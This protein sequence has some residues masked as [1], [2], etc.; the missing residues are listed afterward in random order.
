[1]IT[2]IEK[3]LY[4]SNYKPEICRRVIPVF[5]IKDELEYSIFN[6]RADIHPDHNSLCWILLNEFFNSTKS[7]LLNNGGMYFKFHGKYDNPFEM[8]RLMKSYSYTFTDPE[9]LFSRCD[10]EGYGGGFSEF[11]GNFNEYSASFHYRIYD[12]EMVRQLKA[13]I[14]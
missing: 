11:I 4:N 2:F 3:E 13:E 9:N 14:N 8:I 10:G 5:M 6:R 7:I 12:E 1:M